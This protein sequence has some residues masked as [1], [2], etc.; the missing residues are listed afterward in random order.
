MA[1]VF[2]TAVVEIPVTTTVL[3]VESV[4]IDVV[5]LGVIGP[6]GI[7]GSVGVTGATGQSITGSTGPTGGTGPTGPTGSQGVTGSTGAT[8]ASVTGA[9]GG[10]G[11]TGPTGPT[12][13]TGLTGNTGSTG[14]TG[15][16]GVT[17]ATG[18]TGSTGA[19]S[20]VAGPT[21]PTGATGATG[22]GATGATGVTGS[23]GP[24]GP[25]GQDGFLGGTGAT[26]ATGPTGSNGSNGATGV[27][28]PTGPTGVTGATGT[29]GTIG[30][31]GA[32]GATGATGTNGVTGSTGSTGST[33]PT[34]PTGVTG[35][36]GPS[37]PTGVS[38]VFVGATAPATSI[39]WADTT[40]AASLG[41]PVGGSTGNYL[42]K[43][44]NNDYDTAWSSQA[45]A[46][47]N[48]M[49]NGDMQIA[50]RATSVANI[51]TDTY[52]TT[53]RWRSVM[54]SM[55]TWT[56]SVEN[57]APTGSGFRKSTKMLCT[58]ADASP[59][60]ADYVRLDQRIEGQNL[61]QIAKGTSSAKE[62][63]LSFWV[64]SNVIG[65]YIV[66][67]YDND[68]NR[69]VSKS[70]T[71]N[72]SATWEKKIITIPAD[73][74]GAF[75]ND[76]EASLLLM[77]RLGVGSNYTSGTLQTTWATYADANS[78]VGQV[79]LAAATNNYWQVTGVQLEVGPIATD[80]EFLPVQ[81]ELLMCQRYYIKF[82]QGKGFIGGAGG[83]SNNSTLGRT[84]PTIMRATPTMSHANT[85]TTD[86][87]TA[88]GNNSA[89]TSWHI[90]TD[91]A[92]VV[93]T[94]GNL[95]G[96]G[97]QVVYLEEGSGSPAFV[98]YAIEL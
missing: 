4:Q 5:E 47:K 73:T 1:T 23:T 28:G 86:Y 71:I 87:Y 58:T 33:G 61:Q 53:D 75:D 38:G 22:V 19:A 56:M 24:T 88:G 79:N 50:Q 15:S 27:T 90:G 77:F 65:T 35:T 12:G 43:S 54:S 30:T 14:P 52:N 44:S 84:L 70:Y 72:A 46:F 32:T 96:G 41:V 13:S 37:G 59:S 3:N 25:T 26:G 10:T 51:T 57:D 95:Y 20:T 97:R 94:H 8:G 92:F 68:N 85:R 74:T 9:T 34:G 89:L 6:Q 91:Y 63:S 55:G 2:S 98:E 11:S 49:I 64:K 7:T 80:F 48:I 69:I 82:N 62:L 66:S 31:N 45:T 16:Q 36:T 76:N 21:G 18:S 29:N 42:V 40:I 93:A 81:Q 39:L 78:A 67:L 83:N 60:G 17:G